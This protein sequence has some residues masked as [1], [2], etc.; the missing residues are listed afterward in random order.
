M[1]P[2]VFTVELKG[3]GTETNG[4]I[5]HCQP[6]DAQYDGVLKF[7]DK[8]GKHFCM[9]LDG[10]GEAANVGDVPRGDRNTINYIDL[11]GG[12]RGVRWGCYVG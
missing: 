11:A 12:F 2:A 4:N 6:W 3:V 7:R 8:E 10:R 5:M 1:V 9:V